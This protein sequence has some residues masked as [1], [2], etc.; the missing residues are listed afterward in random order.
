M[1]LAG[2]VALV[3]GGAKRVGRAISLGLAEVGAKVAIHYYHSEDGAQETLAAVKAV[4]GEGFLIRG[5]FSQVDTIRSTVKKCA[6]HYGG[7]DVL[8]NNAAVYSKTPLAETTEDAW[9]ALF[10]VNLKAPF[11]CSQAA[12]KIMKA[13]GSGKIVNIADVAGIVPWPEFIPYSASKAGLL[14][15]TKGLAVA[16]APEIQ[17]NAVA[18]G[19][20]LMAEAAS[21][22]Y[23]KEISEATLLKRI[24]EPADIVNTVL[25]LLT[26]SDYITG[27]VIPV[28]GG[29]LLC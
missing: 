8:I 9:D 6:E 21:T 3:T 1:R 10:T 16:L 23:H 29:K 22:A 18:S 17:V 5:D 28:D 4:G 27:A 15:L 24:G 26:G 12:A 14:S 7:V 25:F 19:T 20:V 11:F 13:R 2:K